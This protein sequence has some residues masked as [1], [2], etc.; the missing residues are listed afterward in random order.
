MEL[1]ISARNTKAMGGSD[2]GADGRENEV[3]SG[4]LM[5]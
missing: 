5:I 1:D 4:Y 2:K 3:G